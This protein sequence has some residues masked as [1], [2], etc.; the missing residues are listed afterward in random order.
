[1]CIRDSQSV[2]ASDALLALQHSVEL[3]A[4][5]DEP[6]YVADVN[7]DDRV[8]AADA[9]LIL[10]KSVQLIDHFPAEE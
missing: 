2:D 7:Q 4:L 6:L 1:M 5:E 8:D 10:Q 9:L 3:I